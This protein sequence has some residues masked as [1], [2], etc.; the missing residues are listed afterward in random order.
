MALEGFSPG[1]GFVTGGDIGVQTGLWRLAGVDTSSWAL[2]QGAYEHNFYVNID[3]SI[4]AKRMAPNSFAARSGLVL[5]PPTSRLTIAAKVCSSP[6][7]LAGRDQR[8][9]PRATYQLQSRR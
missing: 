4:L 3:S 6:V 2:S 5:R 7:L 1:M 9:L 8:Q